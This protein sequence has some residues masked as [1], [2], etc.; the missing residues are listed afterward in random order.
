MIQSYNTST[1]CGV[2]LAQ[3]LLLLLFFFFPAPRTPPQPVAA[4][5][6]PLF[7]AS[8]TPRGLPPPA[9]L[10]AAASPP[11]A[12]PAVSHRLPARYSSP[13]RRLLIRSVTGGT[14]VLYSLRPGATVPHP[15]A[16]VPEARSVV[17]EEGIGVGEV[18]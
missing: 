18:G 14:E 6:S 16:V 4:P 17:Q 10:A 8:A 15:C 1:T 13:L 11:R 12:G 7:F 9:P 5:S 3:K 2:H